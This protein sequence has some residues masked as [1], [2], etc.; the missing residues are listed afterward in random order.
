MQVEI[1]CYSVN[2]TTAL[3]LDGDQ[4]PFRVAMT[5][6]IMVALG[7][8]LRVMIVGRVWASV[9][10]AGEQLAMIPQMN[11]VVGCYSKVSG[12]VPV[13]K[14]ANIIPLYM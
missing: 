13:L 10:A 5:C 2:R 6:S 14:A 8:G 9:L 12:A 7:D 4:V 1:Q 11:V 3:D